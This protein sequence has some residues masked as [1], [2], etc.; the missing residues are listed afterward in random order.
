MKEQFSKAFYAGL[1]V[2][3]LTMDKVKEYGEKMAKEFNLSKEEGNKIV[4]EMQEKIKA[5]KEDMKSSVKKQVQKAIAG[6]DLPTREEFD[7]LKA[8]VEELE[9]GNANEA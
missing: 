9:K 7:A 1:G 3:S 2:A 8:R 5:E 4:E 6:L